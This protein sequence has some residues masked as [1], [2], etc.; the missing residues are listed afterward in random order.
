MVL[1]V[2]QPIKW[3]RNDRQRLASTKKNAKLHGCKDYFFPQVKDN[4]KRLSALPNKKFMVKYFSGNSFKESTSAYYHNC[5]PLLCKQALKKLFHLPVKKNLKKNNFPMQS[6]P[7]I[8]ISNVKCQ[9]HYSYKLIKIGVV[10]CLISGKKYW[11]WSRIWN[12][13]LP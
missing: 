1:L 9:K 5:S 2:I 10:R 13:S 8:R 11:C 4:A 6:G 7:T 3:L 12:T